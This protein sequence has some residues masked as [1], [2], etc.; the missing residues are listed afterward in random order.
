MTGGN[1][2]VRWMRETYV[3]T[4]PRGPVTNDAH[5]YEA[6]PLPLQLRDVRAWDIRNTEYIRP[7]PSCGQRETTPGGGKSCELD[8]GEVC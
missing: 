4:Q 5:A 8:S 7:V 6:L 1:L 2:S 3:C